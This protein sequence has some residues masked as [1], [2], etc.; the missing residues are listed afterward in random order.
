MF[1]VY[2]LVY[3]LSLYF[4]YALVYFPLRLKIDVVKT[5]FSEVL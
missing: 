5:C 1:I 4:Q 3:L 2:T